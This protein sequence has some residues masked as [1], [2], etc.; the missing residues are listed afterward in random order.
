[1]CVKYTLST[2]FHSISKH[3]LLMSAVTTSIF[4]RDRVLGAIMWIL[5]ILTAISRI[6]VGHHY[7]SDLIG[8]AI[9]GSLTSMF[10]EKTTESS[11]LRK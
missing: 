10:V 9:I 7:P 11:S 2:C 6:W 5:S 8:S 1:M 3:V 4:L